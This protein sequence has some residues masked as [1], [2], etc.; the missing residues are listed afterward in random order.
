VAFLLLSAVGY[1]SLVFQPKHFFHLEWVPWWFAAVVVEQG[2][3][4]F[5]AGSRKDD[6]RAP[7]HHR[8]HQWMMLRAHRILLLLVLVLALFGAFVLVR[9]HQQTR[10]T[11]LVDAYSHASEERVATVAT[12]TD[13]GSTR[14]LLSGL[15]SAPHPTPLVDDYLVLEVECGA[16]EDADI[17]GVYDQ[18]TSPRERMTVP[19]SAASRHWKLFWPIY[20]YPPSSRFGWFEWSS[21]APIR[22][23]A[24]HRVKDLSHVPVLLK[25]TVPDDFGSR[26]W[27][28]TLRPN[29][30]FDRLGVRL[31]PKG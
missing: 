10:V 25:L 20:Q 13:D 14:L 28:Q 18:P 3:M 1:V 15:G 9:Q 31:S 22:I 2:V 23:A 21:D 5:G 6:S 24:V 4:L 29:F 26:R 30:F 11:A 27:Y 17:M 7:A 12:V 8:L 16:A 19:C